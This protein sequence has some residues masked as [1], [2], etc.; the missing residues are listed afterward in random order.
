[1][2]IKCSKKIPFKR[3]Y[4]KFFKA[5]WLDICIQYEAYYFTHYLPS[6]ILGALKKYCQTAKRYLVTFLY[7]MCLLLRKAII[8]PL[9]FSSDMTNLNFSFL[10]A[11]TR[12]GHW[13][14][15]WQRTR[16]NITTLWKRWAQRNRWKLFQGLGYVFWPSLNFLWTSEKHVDDERNYFFNVYLSR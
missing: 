16:R 10:I 4:L 11:V 8:D 12:V 7:K 6:H 1:M 5:L 9:V 3:T 15:S 13:K 14:C 2:K